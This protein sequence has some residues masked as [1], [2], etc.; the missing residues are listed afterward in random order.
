MID[1]FTDS[2]W[3]SDKTDRKSVTCVVTMIGEH[4]IRMPNCHTICTGFVFW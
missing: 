2:D 4:C 1:I 3:A